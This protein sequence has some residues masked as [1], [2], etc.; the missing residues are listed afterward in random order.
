MKTRKRSL[1][2]LA[3]LL[4]TACTSDPPPLSGAST[5][6]AA[7]IDTIYVSDPSLPQYDPDAAEYAEFPGA[8]GQLA[9]MGED[10]IDAA[11]HLAVAMRFPRPDSF[12]AAQALLSLGPDITA[13]AL[14]HLIDNLRYDRSEVRIY[15]ALLVGSVGAAAS[16]AVA[17]VA[18]LLW[19]DDPQVRTTAALALEKVTQR[20]LVEDEI[21]VPL[22]PSLTVDSLAPD[23]P[24]GKISTAARNWW[25]RQGSKINWRPVYGICDP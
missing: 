23:T 19:D 16:C 5:P 10:A 6:V 13:A 24:P 22:T 18:P 20:D 3:L 4:T 1:L 25:T 21:E 8:V 17:D 11:S 2:L 14:P 15:S 7:L 9:E 12:L